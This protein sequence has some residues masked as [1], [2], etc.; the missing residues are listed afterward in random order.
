MGTI[1]MLSLTVG[2]RSWP[3]EGALVVGSVMVKDLISLDREW[4]VDVVK[5][6]FPVFEAEYP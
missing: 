3:V 4:K 1:L 2:S 6:L 5:E